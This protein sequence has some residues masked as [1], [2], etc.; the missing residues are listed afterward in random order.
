MILQRCR[1]NTCCSPYFRHRWAS[2][3]KEKSLKDS[4]RPQQQQEWLSGMEPQGR[5]GIQKWVQGQ[6]HLHQPKQAQGRNTSR[7]H[8]TKQEKNP[9]TISGTIGRPNP[10]R[11]L[12][13]IQQENVEGYAFF[14]HKG[15]S[16]G[17]DAAAFSPELWMEINLGK[18]NKWQKIIDCMQIFLTSLVQEFGSLSLQQQQHMT[19]LIMNVI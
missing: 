16:L 1:L 10:Q 19:R 15:S 8:Y 3:V 17:A 4:T 12:K 14:C 13:S 7:S 9:E 2:T 5:L 11:S 18:H 6:Q